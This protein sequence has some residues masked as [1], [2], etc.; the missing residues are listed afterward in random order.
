MADGIASQRTL[1][2]TNITPREARAERA[3]RELA[4]RDLIVFSEYVAPFYHAARH[5][6]LV[7]KYLHEVYKFIESGGTQGIGR[8]MIFQ[9]PRHGK[10]E[11]AAQLFPAWLMGK[12]PDSRIILTAYGAD[13]SQT[14]SRAIRNYVTGVRYR[15]VFGELSAVDAPVQL[16]DDSRAVSAWDLAAPHRGGVVAAGVGGG[17][18]GKGAHLLVIDDPFKNRDE[19]ESEAY[20]QKVW[21]WYASSAYTRLENGGAIVMMHTRWH[22][23]DL[24]GMLLKQMGGGDALADKWVVVSL[25]DIASSEQLAV[26]SGMRDDLLSGLWRDEKDPLGRQDGEALWA[27]KYSADDLKRIEA[28][29]G[30]YDYA[31]LYRQQPRPNAGG[32]FEREWFANAVVPHKPE[33][34]RWVRYVDL[35]ISEKASADY[36]ATVAMAMDKEGNVYLRDMIRVRGWYEF[37]EQLIAAMTSDLERGVEWAIEGV[38]FQSLA[39]QE[40][41]RDPRLAAVAIREIKPEGDKVARARPLQTLARGGKL[42]LVGGAWVNAFIAEALD[43]PKGRHDDQIDSASGG[44]EMIANRPAADSLVSFVQMDEEIEQE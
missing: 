37:K 18:T 20:R 40:L 43:F 16:S 1:A 33:G 8:L 44:L 3:R 42:K 17:I 28:N 26:S 35:A 6:R 27:E 34:L 39:F 24:A 41:L 4:R 29:V 10:T 31:A 23:D 5:H 36:N 38:A 25:P 9:P 30:P 21:T 22:P 15:A 7:A 2:M 12:L 19:A 14:S 32:F 11:Q 13:L